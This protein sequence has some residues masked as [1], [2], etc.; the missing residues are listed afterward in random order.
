MKTLPGGFAGGQCT[1]S[2][3]V[4][5]FLVKGRKKIKSVTSR[6]EIFPA[7]AGGKVS[8]GGGRGEGRER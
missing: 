7:G 2:L 8:G 1:L 5:R 3:L 6:A 4:S